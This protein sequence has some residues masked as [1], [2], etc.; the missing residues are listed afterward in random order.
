[1][2]FECAPRQTTADFLTALTSPGERRIQPGYEILV[3]RTADEFV[4]TWK[5]SKTYQR[6]LED[7]NLYNERYPIGGSAV[8]AFVESRRAQQAVQQ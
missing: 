3:P 1:M 4:E 6:L 8:A 5:S 2:G 7:I